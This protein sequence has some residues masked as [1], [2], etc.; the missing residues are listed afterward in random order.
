MSI[1]GK[2]VR[3][4]VK[5][6]IS[7]GIDP[8][9]LFCSAQSCS[10]CVMSPIEVGIEPVKE[11]PLPRKLTRVL[12]NWNNSGKKN[13]PEKLLLSRSSNVKLVRDPS[14][15]G[16]VPLILF[17]KT[18]STDSS[19]SFAISEGRVPARLFESFCIQRERWCNWNFWWDDIGLIV[20][21]NQESSWVRTHI[22]I[23]N[24]TIDASNTVPCTLIASSKPRIF[25]E[26]AISKRAVVENSKD[27]PLTDRTDTITS[28]G[29]RVDIN[30]PFSCLILGRSS[31][32]RAC[33]RCNHVVD[34]PY[35]GTLAIACRGTESFLNSWW[36]ESCNKIC[37]NVSRHCNEQANRE[38]VMS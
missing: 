18:R 4:F 6:V 2:N 20:I 7:V 32:Y 23:I 34:I 17:W 5:L 37:K 11:F 30:Q 16:T 14:S 33:D 12:A 22:E 1:N 27:E 8:V 24:S 21:N 3:R 38:K 15:V 36:L 25:I 35:T 26:P 19:G 9:K 29:C 10:S 31:D 13:G 28:I